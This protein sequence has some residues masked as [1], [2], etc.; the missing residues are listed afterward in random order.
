MSTVVIHYITCLCHVTNHMMQSKHRPPSTSSTHLLMSCHAMT[1]SLRDL[2][3]QQF[4][5]CQHC[6]Q[7]PQLPL[8]MMPL[9]LLL[10]ILPLLPQEALKPLRLLVHGE[11]CV[12]SQIGHCQ[13]QLD[14]NAGDQDLPHK[15][16]HIMKRQL[17]M[18]TGRHA[19]LAAIVKVA[20]R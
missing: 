6:Q 20:A 5:D 3:R 15:H 9:V 14:W 19:T 8:K 18:Q 2:G 7:E 12:L 11:V 17:C 10:V 16:R 13:E 4:E 1:Q